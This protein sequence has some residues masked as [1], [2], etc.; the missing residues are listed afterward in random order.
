MRTITISEFNLG[1]IPILDAECAGRGN[2][3]V[4]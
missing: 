2:G 3:D 4:S 1:E